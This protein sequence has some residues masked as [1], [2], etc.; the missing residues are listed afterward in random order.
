VVQ[1][2]VLSPDYGWNA[3]GVTIWKERRLNLGENRPDLDP[4]WPDRFEPAEKVGKTIYLWYFP[5]P[6]SHTPGPRARR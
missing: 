5:P 2:N 6:G 4:L 3:V 1:P